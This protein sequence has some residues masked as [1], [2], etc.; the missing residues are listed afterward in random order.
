[1]VLADSSSSAA[2]SRC[3][4]A[5]VQQFTLRP[6]FAGVSAADRDNALTCPPLEGVSRIS[7]RK[8][9]RLVPAEGERAKQ[10][11][12]AVRLPGPVLTVPQRRFPLAATA[13]LCEES[14]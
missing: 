9:R 3:C 12:Q 7:V 5:G 4:T 11:P 13:V 6:F 2:V 14:S 8:R 1:M 10:S